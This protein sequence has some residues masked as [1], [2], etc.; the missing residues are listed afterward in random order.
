LALLLKANG[1]NFEGL[2]TIPVWHPET[3]LERLTSPEK[4]SI[5]HTK[6]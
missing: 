4:A 5:N 2:A 1:G 3:C 6:Q